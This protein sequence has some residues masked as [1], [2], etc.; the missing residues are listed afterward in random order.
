[1]LEV[2]AMLGGVLLVA[3]AL[4]YVA[5]GAPPVVI[6]VP[7][8]AHR[9]L[10]LAPDSR[11]VLRGEVGT[12]AVAMRVPRRPGDGVDIAVA[13]PLSLSAGLALHVGRGAAPHLGANA[14]E[15]ARA[16]FSDRRVTAALARASIDLW[17]DDVSVRALASPPTPAHL[18]GAVDAATSVALALVAARRQ[19]RGVRP[20]VDVICAEIAEEH[21]G[22]YDGRAGTIEISRKGAVIA[23]AVGGAPVTAVAALDP[24][25]GPLAIAWLAPEALLHHDGRDPSG[26]SIDPDDDAR[27]AAIRRAAEPMLGHLHSL[28][29]DPSRLEVG[30]TLAPDDPALAP[31]VRALVAL[32]RAVRDEREGGPFR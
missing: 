4:R 17:I 16:I 30:L 2:V 13:L 21:G 6:D 31:V 27:A 15:I 3:V 10:G 5:S 20:S 32:V 23:I 9:E 8:W 18:L 24:P 22:V 11:G 25:L 14:S 1:M 12:L 7:A 28:R 19:A 26:I 29:G